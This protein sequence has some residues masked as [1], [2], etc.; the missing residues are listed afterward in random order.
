MVRF[1]WPLP[2][3]IART[4]NYRIQVELDPE[5]KT[6]E[7]RQTVTWSNIQEQPTD[8]LWFH[9]YW[10]AWRNN[11]STWMLENRIRR[12]FSGR[13]VEEADWG[14]IEVSSVRLLPGMGYLGGG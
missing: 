7:G 1:D 6:L 14:Y 11:R 5:S 12:R 9:L 8:E 3:P 10:N 13:D 4:T 2:R